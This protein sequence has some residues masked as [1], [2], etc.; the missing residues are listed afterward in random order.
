MD[1]Q[2]TQTDEAVRP[3]AEQRGSLSTPCA[4]PLMGLLADVRDELV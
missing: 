1:R 2:D 3:R 4:R